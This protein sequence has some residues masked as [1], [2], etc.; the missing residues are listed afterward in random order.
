MTPVELRDPVLS[1]AAHVER[2]EAADT[3]VTEQSTETV[4]VPCDEVGVCHIVIVGARV[5][6]PV[7][8]RLFGNKH[9]VSAGQDAAAPK[10]HDPWIGSIGVT[11]ATAARGAGT[12]ENIHVATEVGRQGIMPTEIPISSRRS[13]GSVSS[14][15]SAAIM[16]CRVH[17]EALADLPEVRDAGYLT[18]LFDGAMEHR[19]DQGGEDGDYRDN[20]QNLYER[21]GRVSFQVGSGTSEEIRVAMCSPKPDLIHP[22]LGRDGGGLCFRSRQVSNYRSIL[23]H[24]H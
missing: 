14:D 10:Q 22:F 15:W 4:S 8:I 6:G 1:E 21:K 12:A 13:R 18:A 7:S 24:V 3:A 9:S 23:V 17:I 19:E 16:I 20:H 5:A 11:S 2:G